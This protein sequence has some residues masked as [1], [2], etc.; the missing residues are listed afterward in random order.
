MNSASELEPLILDFNHRPKS[1][2]LIYRRVNIALS[3]TGILSGI[4]WIDK[5]MLR[6]SLIF[7]QG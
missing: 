5:V 3:A 1:Y 7:F 2:E 4:A 6:V